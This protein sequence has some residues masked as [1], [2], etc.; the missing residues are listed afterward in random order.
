M[1]FWAHG[2]RRS[3]SQALMQWRKL[4]FLATVQRDSEATKLSF[5]WRRHG[6]SRWEIVRDP[7]YDRL[8]MVLALLWKSKLRQTLCI[9]V[10][11]TIS[12]FQESAHGRT[13]PWSSS[14]STML[15]KIPGLICYVFLSLSGWFVPG[16]WR[17]FMASQ[18]WP[19]FI[20]L[21]GTL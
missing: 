14:N 10:F 12:S 15:H 4:R 1:D 13:M 9:I 18:A 20:S 11:H 21:H 19:T 5:G 16:K 6:K 7:D 8:G 2:W 3:G 17:V